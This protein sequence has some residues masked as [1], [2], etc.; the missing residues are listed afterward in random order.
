MRGPYPEDSP[1][2]SGRDGAPPYKKGGSG[3]Y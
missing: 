3:G 1:G 2:T